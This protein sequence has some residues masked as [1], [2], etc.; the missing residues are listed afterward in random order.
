MWRDKVSYQFA[1]KS[2]Q[3]SL[4][5]HIFFSN[6]RGLKNQIKKGTILS[7]ENAS[8]DFGLFG[9]VVLPEQRSNS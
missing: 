3:N 5:S 7:S 1:L 9:L 4:F 6:L 8:C 2:L